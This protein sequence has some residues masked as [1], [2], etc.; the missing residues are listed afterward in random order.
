M[1]KILYVEDHVDTREAISKLLRLAGHEV[2]TA[3][4]GREALACLFARK[5]DLLLL[6]L[7]LPELDGVK[8]IQVLRLYLRLAGL[9]IVVLTGVAAGRLY[10]QVQALN[11]S[12]I[13]IKSMTEF[14]QL[15][16]AIRNALAQPRSANVAGSDDK[17]CG[18]LP[19][20]ASH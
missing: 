13:L 12:A 18:E 17:S 20:P 2:E 15:L 7:T 1:P 10:E 16:S 14:D 8:I 6:D 3:G 5:P 9:P 19:P 4:S 11:P